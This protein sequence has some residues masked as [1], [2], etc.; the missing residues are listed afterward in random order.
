MENIGQKMTVS[1]VRPPQKLW[2]THTCRM[3]DSCRPLFLMQGK[4]I[5]SWPG[6]DCRRYS[7]SRRVWPVWNYILHIDLVCRYFSDFLDFVV[8][9]SKFG[10]SIYNHSVPNYALFFDVRRRRQKR[11]LYM[12]F[13]VLNSVTPATP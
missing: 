4:L 12:L 11:M 6:R 8:E 9:N 13:S 7:I 10:V 3:N 1:S 5:K 2:L